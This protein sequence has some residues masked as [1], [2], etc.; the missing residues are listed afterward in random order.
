VR[1]MTCIVCPMGCRMKVANV[2]GQLQ[3]EGN[4]CRRGEAYARDE[5][6]A[7]KR[8]VTSVVAVAGT[9]Q[10]LAVKTAATVP[11]ELILAVMEEIRRVRVRGAVKVGQVLRENLAG[12]GVAL[13]ATKNLIPSQ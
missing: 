3:V 9:S 11:K 4:S 13:V 2:N 6:M 10:L 1:E 12:T 5:V 7:P 8:V